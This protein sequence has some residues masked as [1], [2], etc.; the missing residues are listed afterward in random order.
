MY[1]STTEENKQNFVQACQETLEL[2]RKGEPGHCELSLDA[3][4]GPIKP[5]LGAGVVTAARLCQKPGQKSNPVSQPALTAADRGGVTRAP[6]VRLPNDRSCAPDV[7]TPLGALMQRI[8]QGISLV[9]NG[10]EVVVGL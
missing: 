10:V 7:A 9:T 4:K 2:L 8:G 6:P 5:W 3:R 1:Q